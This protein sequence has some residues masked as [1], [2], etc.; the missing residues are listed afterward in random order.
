VHSL[1]NK[2]ILKVND[3]IITF[4]DVKQEEKYLIILNQNLKKID[5]NRLNI[6]AVRLNC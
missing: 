1:E 5:Q 3:K 6:L 2:I 4:F